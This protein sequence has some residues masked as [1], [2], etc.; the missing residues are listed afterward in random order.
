MI[1]KFKFL[2]FMLLSLLFLF[3]CVER[4]TPE[5][6]NS[7]LREG[8]YDEAL[9]IYEAILK[10]KPGDIVSLKSVADI[11]LVK[12][13]F[14]GAIQ[15]YKKVIEAN[16]AY[17][18]RELVSMLSYS[19]NVRDMA[20]DVIKDIGNGRTEVISEILKRI[21]EG[22]N[23]VKIDHLNA[24]ARIGKPAS[25]CAG[26]VAEYLDNDYFGIRKA[27]LETLGTF[28][29]LN[30]KSS[31]AIDK[32]LERLNDENIVVVA[33]AIKNFGILKGGANETV[34]ALIKMLTR[35]EE[36]RDLAKKAISDIG[37]A[38]KSTVSQLAA[39]TDGKNPNIIRIATIDTFAAMGNQAN[40]AVPVLIPL[41][42]DKNHTI[43]IASANALTRVG[44]PS[45]EAIPGLINLLK[46]N[47][48]DVKLRAI[49]ELSDM[50]KSASSALTF[51]SNLSSKDTNKEVRQEAKKAYDKIYK[52]KR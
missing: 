28:D 21:A 32:M 40:D 46:H 7:L 45:N 39:L 3:A 35:Q 43:R 16:P 50:G 15:G 29:A 33:E 18:V 4:N 9:V 31:G 12:K 34:P 47:N 2:H 10:K 41:L 20:S 27:A 36:I 11:K 5:K 38:A 6:A 30:L 42:Q 22:N 17:G 37:A 26:T 8:K 24:L 49:A 44:K 19:K 51:L 1:G 23:Y 48:I 14:Q 13:D 52:A 25:F